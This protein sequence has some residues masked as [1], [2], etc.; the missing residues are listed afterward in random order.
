MHRPCLHTQHCT[1][2][3]AADRTLP[4]S[5]TFPP[6]NNPTAMPVSRTLP[7]KICFVKTSKSMF[8]EYRDFTQK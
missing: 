8:V 3:D 6:Q 7:S 5:A 2:Q 1:A 4:C